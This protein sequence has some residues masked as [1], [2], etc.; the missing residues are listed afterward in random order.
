MPGRQV[1]RRNIHRVLAAGFALVILLLLAAGFVGVVN[2]RSIRSSTSS[3]LSEQIVTTRLIHEIRDEQAALGAVFHRLARDPEAIDR[4]RVLRQLDDAG[5]A[6]HNTVAAAAGTP[7]EK[8]WR[9]LESAAVSFSNE[10]R[11][12]IDQPK[13]DRSAMRRLVQEHDAVIAIIVKLVDASSLRASAAQ[14]HIEA[15]SS[16]LVRQSAALLGACLL[17]AVLSTILTV[18]STSLLLRKMEEQATELSRVSWH[19]LDKQ[20]TVARRF[21]HELHDELGQTMTAVKANLLAMEPLP[22]A[23]RERRDDCVRLVDTAI[24]NIR[25][26]SQLLRPTILDDFGLAAGLTWLAERFSARTGIQVDCKSNGHARLPEDTE[27]HLFRIAQEALTNVARHSAAKNVTI[28]LAVD[29]ARVELRIADDGK[30][31]SSGAPAKRGMGMIGMRARAR[32]AGGELAVG[33]SPA[34]GVEIRVKLPRRGVPH[35]SKDPDLVS[36]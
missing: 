21:S 25:E 18:R 13:D 31:L 15:Y 8:L 2:V 22:G 28:S 24:G 30:G 4:D 6:I 29:D 23:A 10:V 5:A 26:L 36:R 32:S 34:G 3:L 7:E 1:T 19:M 11:R 14:A 16:S 35:E 27:T 20:E 12:F 17:L 9:S 33:E